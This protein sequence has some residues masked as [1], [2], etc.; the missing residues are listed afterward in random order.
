MGVRIALSLQDTGQLR[1]LPAK[2]R[3]TLKNEQNFSLLQRVVQGT[4]PKGQLAVM[5]PASEFGYRRDGG[6]GHP[7]C[8]NI[9]YGLRVQ[10]SDDHDL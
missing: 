2:S 8:D 1:A 10:T 7:R 3:Q 9:P 4:D 5:E 6:F